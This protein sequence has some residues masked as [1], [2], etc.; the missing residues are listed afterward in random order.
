MINPEVEIKHK[1]G[2][3]SF[4]NPRLFQWQNEFKNLIFFYKKNFGVV[5]AGVLRVLIWKSLIL[6]IITFALLGKGGISRTYAKIL[7]SI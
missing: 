2:G 6:R 1:G 3:S 5:R 4:E 7:V